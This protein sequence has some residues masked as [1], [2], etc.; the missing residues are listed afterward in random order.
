MKR[1]L[2]IGSLVVFFVGMLAGLAS[3]DEIPKPAPDPIGQEKIHIPVVPITDEDQV[4]EEDLPKPIPKPYRGPVPVS[5][6]SEDT[7]YVIEAAVPLIILHSPAGCVSVS[8][9]EGPVKILGKFADGTG[10]IETRTFA[11]KNL[12]FINALKPGTIE[13]LIIPIGVQ[14]ETEIIRQ[15][16]VVMGTAP[17]PGPDPKPEPKPDPPPPNSG[18]VSIAIVEDVL[19]RHPDTAIVL[20][21]IATWNELKDKGHDWRLYDKATTEAKGKQA[22]ADAAG[23]EL[24]A[25]VIRDKETSAI[26]RVVPLPKT[27]DAVKRVLS[28]LG[29]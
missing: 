28:E 18:K 4:P 10:K 14:A 7:W 16:L 22:V 8:H 2:I 26:L 5:A 1:F 17:R 12:Y 11:S 25:M 13:L 20:N 23:T 27:I 9:E 29:V 3:C 19:N 24:P 6:L 15:P 21:A